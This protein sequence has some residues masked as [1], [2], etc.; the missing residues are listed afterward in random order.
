M[1]RFQ[2]KIN[3]EMVPSNEYM[4]IV[5]LRLAAGEEPD[6]LFPWP[7]TETDRWGAQG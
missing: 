3:F 5:E 7:K 1:K 4:Q 2:L 6:I